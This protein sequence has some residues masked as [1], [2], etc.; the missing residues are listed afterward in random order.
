MDGIQAS[1]ATA[2]RSTTLNPDSIK[3]IV[4]AFLQS[5]YG[6]V[7]LDH[8]AL[9]S[10]IEELFQIQRL[11]QFVVT[12][13]AGLVPVQDD[14]EDKKKKRKKRKPAKAVNLKELPWFEALLHGVQD[15]T[16]KNSLPVLLAAS[17]ML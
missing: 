15:V 6:D 16:T 14:D 17:G 8:P 10:G 12:Q 3:R 5:F 9:I 4:S 2:L 11:L 7:V 1:L 13:K